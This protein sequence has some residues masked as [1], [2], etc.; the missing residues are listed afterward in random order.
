MLF[1]AEEMG[2]TL[3]ELA[4]RLGIRVPGVGFSVERGRKIAQQNDYQLIE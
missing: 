4:R 2:I 3:A 1:G